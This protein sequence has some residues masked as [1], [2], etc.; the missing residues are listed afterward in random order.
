MKFDNNKDVTHDSINT[1][2]KV[3]FLSETEKHIAIVLEVRSGGNYVIAFYNQVWDITATTY[4]RIFPRVRDE[5][6][7]NVFEIYDTVLINTELSKTFGIVIGYEIGL[8]VIMKYAGKI[9]RRVVLPSSVLEHHDNKY[10]EILF[11][12]RRELLKNHSW[13]RWSLPNREE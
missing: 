4:E 11:N 1:G 12:N 13:I 3:W 2:D 9:W 10:D 5:K 7:P 6:L 8:H